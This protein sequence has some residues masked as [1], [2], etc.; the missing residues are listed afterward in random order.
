ME[1]EVERLDQLKASKMKEL[2]LKK[3]VELEEICK[4]SHMEMP[5]SAEM[6]HIMKLIISGKERWSQSKPKI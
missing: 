3:K 6:D 2:F 5:S 4:K 1:A